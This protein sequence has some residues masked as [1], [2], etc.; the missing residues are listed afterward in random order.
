MHRSRSYYIRLAGTI[1]AIGN[2]ILCAIKLLFGWK[3]GSL[4]VIGDGIDSSTD[5][6]IALTAIFVSGIVA[7]PGDSD[8]P[9]GH[10]R[11]ET[12]ATLIL[13]CV[14][15]YAGLQLTIT[16]IS[17]IIKGK[18][19]S[20]ISWLAVAAAAIS[21]CGK[22]LLAL[23]QFAIAKI[24]DSEIVK[25]NAENMKSDIILS[26]G[27]LAGLLASHFFAQPLLDPICAILVGFWV[28][29]N[30]VRLF[31]EIN[32]ELMDGNAD[33]SLYKKLFAAASSVPGVKNPHRARIRK[34]ASCFDIDLDIE[35][36]PA[37]T[38]YD[39]HELCE[40]VEEAVMEKIDNVYGIVVHIEPEGSADHQREEEYGLTPD[41]VK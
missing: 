25:A 41:A 6:L 30:A 32:L 33:N 3:T 15:F 31:K 26:A 13:S 10:G 12:T 24:S 23:S 7:Q 1:A 20:E 11:A 28:I 17:S 35:V 40:Q 36:D 34:I 5:V 4:A 22:A 8:H 16:S 2:L 9:W 37:M 29:K 18:I 14:I 27:V 39:A 38:V 19:A 21:I